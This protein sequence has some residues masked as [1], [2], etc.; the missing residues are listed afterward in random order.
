M[1]A[2]T[3]AT[4]ADPLPE[5]EDGVRTVAGPEMEVDSDET[6][7]EDPDA[8][9]DQAEIN[10]RRPVMVNDNAFI[11]DPRRAHARMH[12]QVPYYP[13]VKECHSVASILP[14]SSYMAFIVVSYIHKNWKGNM[15]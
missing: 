6:M 11:V 12:M 7:E 10:E 3:A 15:R 9:P 14:A 1:H 5:P 8:T 13:H 4:C 2:A